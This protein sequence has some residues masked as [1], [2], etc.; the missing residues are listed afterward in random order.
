[1]IFEPQVVDPRSWKNWCREALTLTGRRPVAF[2]ALTLGLAAFAVIPVLGD[3]LQMILLPLCLG[4]GCRLASQADNGG[5]SRRAFT[6]LSVRAFGHL[7][8]LGLIPL[9]VAGV[10]AALLNAL[11]MVEP[12]PIYRDGLPVAPWIPFEA[13]IGIIVSLV[14][15]LFLSGG[16]IWTLP[17]LMA[18]ADL[19]LSIAGDQAVLALERNS[20]LLR[21]AWGIAGGLFLCLLPLG[22]IV[23]GVP[24]V[25]AFPFLCCL[26]YV[27]YRHIWLGRPNNQ[28]RWRQAVSNA[29]IPAQ[30]TV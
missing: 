8:V 13:G 9:A 5:P 23:G 26:M 28:P 11:Q 4:L 21:L 3:T 15:W 1:M 18:L 12:E 7:A 20:L 10:L 19:P 29:L 27:I 17:P 6:G 16:L 25:L 2:V 30:G 14:M 24:A 22:L